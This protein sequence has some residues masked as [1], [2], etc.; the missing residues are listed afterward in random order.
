L[1]FQGIDLRDWYLDGGGRS[2]LTTRR[3][4]VLVDHL[5]VDSPL[6]AE[7]YGE[8]FTHSQLVRMEPVWPGQPHFL[9][10]YSASRQRAR[11]ATRGASR[12]EHY[13][14]KKAEQEAAEGTPEQQTEDE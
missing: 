6:W 1:A 9:H 3:L 2:R 14:R 13:R 4:Q 8:G 11:Q 5:G 7:V 10:P 12:A